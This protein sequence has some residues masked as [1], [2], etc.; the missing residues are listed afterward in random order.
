MSEEKRNVKIR[1]YHFSD[2]QNGPL[3][4]RIN[5]VARGLFL[6]EDY[7]FKGKCLIDIH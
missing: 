5:L 4:E 1:N 3:Y 6:C 7:Y 2:F